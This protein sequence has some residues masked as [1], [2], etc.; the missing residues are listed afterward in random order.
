VPAAGN[1]LLSLMRAEDSLGFDTAGGALRAILQT[2]DWEARLDM[3]PRLREM[4]RDYRQRAQVGK[5]FHSL[6]ITP[7]MRQS[8]QQGQPMWGNALVRQQGGLIRAATLRSLRG[9]YA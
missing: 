2:P 3:S 9:S 8:I 1:E 4:L 7:A 6:D 5:Q